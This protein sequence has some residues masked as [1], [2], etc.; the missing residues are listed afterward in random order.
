MFLIFLGCT[1]TAFHSITER[2]GLRI[3]RRDRKTFTIRICKANAE[4]SRLKPFAMLM[5]KKTCGWKNDPYG[6]SWILMS[7]QC[8]YSLGYLR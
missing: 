3:T 4:A 2:V 6:A 1:P 5:K 7:L 8:G